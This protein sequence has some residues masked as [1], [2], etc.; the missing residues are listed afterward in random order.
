MSPPSHLSPRQIAA[1]LNRS[2]RKGLTAEGRQ[3]LIDTAH[4]NKPWTHSTGPKTAIGKARVAV[5]ARGR[6][7][8]PHSVR[9][10]RRLIGEARDLAMSMA[11]LRLLLS[12][13]AAG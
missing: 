8:G 7:R 1:K 6:Q 11:A 9:E 10:L 5:N 13:P 3:R 2:K 12:Q 4:Q